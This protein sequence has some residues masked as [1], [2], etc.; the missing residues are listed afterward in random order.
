VTHID[1]SRQAIGCEPA[2]PPGDRLHRLRLLPRVKLVEDA[3][4]R[5]GLVM[6]VVE[7][8]GVVDG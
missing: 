5:P 2:A 3:A 6:T 1:D 4:I 8:H 7:L